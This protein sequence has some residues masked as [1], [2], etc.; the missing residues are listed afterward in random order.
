[1]W[2]RSSIDGGYSEPSLKGRPSAV[3]MSVS[4]W[5]SRKKRGEN[6]KRAEGKRKAALTLY[7]DVRPELLRILVRCV[8][9]DELSRAGAE[10]THAELLT[11]P[12]CVSIECAVD[13]FTRS[14][15]DLG[16]DV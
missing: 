15:S 8:D 16:R 2:V 12:L 14:F 4:A 6:D 1:M 11:R 10:H 7:F 13:S 9:N 3:Y 5:R